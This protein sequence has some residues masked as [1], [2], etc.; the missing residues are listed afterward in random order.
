MVLFSPEVSA[1]E[2]FMMWH[3]LVH[4]LSHIF[5][6]MINLKLCLMTH[7]FSLHMLYQTLRIKKK[8]I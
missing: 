5:C 8:E 1:M 7:A 6:I 2:G 3:I 4:M